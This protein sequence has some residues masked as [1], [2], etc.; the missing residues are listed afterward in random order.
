MRFVDSKKP[1]MSMTAAVGW[2]EMVGFRSVLEFQD[3]RGPE[4]GTGRG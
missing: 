1:T 3:V 4:L 2:G